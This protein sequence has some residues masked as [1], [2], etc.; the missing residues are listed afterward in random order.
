MLA[1]QSNDTKSKEK[2]MA[3]PGLK[4][5]AVTGACGNLG[6]KLVQTCIAAAWCEEVVGLDIHPWPGSESKV[7]SVVADLTDRRDRRWVD[8]LRGVD[9]II[10]FAANNP[11]VSATW[12]QMVDSVDMTLNLSGAALEMGV[13][14]FIFASSNHVMGGYKEES[15]RMAP[16]SLTVD[17][18]PRPGTQVREPDG[19]LSLPHAYAVTKLTGER[20]CRERALG[21]EGRLTTIS[22]RIGWCQPGENRPETLNPTG[23]AGAPVT[24]TMDAEALRDLAWFRNMWLSNQ[25]FSQVFERAVL[26]D[27]SAWP[28][29]GIIVNGMSNNS[30]MPWDIAQTKRL[31]GYRPV[32]DVSAA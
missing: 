28:E 26:A 14:R 17:L 27:A 20:I 29:P 25:D 22:V 1:T 4:K 12:E 32:D 5:V 31:I 18:P 16:G 3:A 9:A 24:A 15:D 13:G 6:R 23:V 7:T 30:G 19:S 2:A 21:A 11:Q 10:H 8:A